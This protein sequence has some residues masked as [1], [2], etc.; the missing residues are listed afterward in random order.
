VVIVMQRDAPSSF[1]PV[2]WLP[3]PGDAPFGL[4]FRIYLPGQQVLDGGWR[5]PPL[6]LQT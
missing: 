2:N 6:E 5:V 3:T 4:V 1:A